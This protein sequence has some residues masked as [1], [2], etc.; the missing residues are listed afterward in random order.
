[1]LGS[2]RLESGNQSAD[3]PWALRQND[4]RKLVKDNVRLNAVKTDMLFD[5]LEFKLIFV[6]ELVPF[7]KWYQEAIYILEVD[8]NLMNLLSKLISIL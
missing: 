7:E 1:M 8:H 6:R 2:R 4:A 3:W 5:L